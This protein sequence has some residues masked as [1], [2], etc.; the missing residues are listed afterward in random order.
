MSQTYPPAAPTDFGIRYNGDAADIRPTHIW[1]LF[2]CGE[3]KT[4]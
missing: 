2:W 3:G 1:A 4:D